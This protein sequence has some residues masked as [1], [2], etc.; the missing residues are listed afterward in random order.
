ME[1]GSAVLG[2][3]KTGENLE[4]VHGLQ[5][6]VRSNDRSPRLS[7]Q[8]SCRQRAG[9]TVLNRSITKDRAD[10]TLARESDQKWSLGKRAGNQTGNRIQ[11]LEIL[12]D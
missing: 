2:L 6:I 12:G 5:N 10:E 9:K 8:Q 4:R 3:F 1:R 7:G 11:K